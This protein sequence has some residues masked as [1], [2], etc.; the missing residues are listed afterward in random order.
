[1]VLFYPSVFCFFSWLLIG[2]SSTP[3]ISSLDEIRPR[4]D[5]SK[6]L[7]VVFK[8]IWGAV[9][10]ITDDTIIS[11]LDAA[12]AQATQLITSLVRQLIN[13]T[14]KERE[15][16]AVLLNAVFAT[17]F[18]TMYSLV[19]NGSV[20]LGYEHDNSD[21]AAFNL[22]S[23]DNIRLVVDGRTSGNYGWQVLTIPIKPDINEQFYIIED[24]ETSYRI[25]EITD[26]SE[27]TNFFLREKRQYAHR[28]LEGS[29]G[30]ISFNQ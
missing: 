13:G 2:C 25:R 16:T 15:N 6:K 22:N 21:V 20:A 12:D 24:L 10:I 28:V 14:P 29:K 18:R 26:V 5:S 4:S 27:V 1:M 7:I 9:F 23:T 11:K 3:A 8:E 17:H 19:R 30:F